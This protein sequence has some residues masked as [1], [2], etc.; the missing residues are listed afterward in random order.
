MGTTTLDEAQRDTLS[1]EEIRERRAEAATQRAGREGY[2]QIA[3]LRVMVESTRK[4]SDIRQ[5]TVITPVQMQEM[6]EIRLSTP[7]QMRRTPSSQGSDSQDQISPAVMNTDPDSPETTDSASQKPSV[8]PQQP[9]PSQKP[10]IPNRRSNVLH[11]AFERGD[12]E[13]TIQRLKQH[14]REAESENHHLRNERGYIHHVYAA[15]KEETAAIRRDFQDHIEKTRFSRQKMEEK[16]ELIQK[17]N[18]NLREYITSMSKAQEP[19]RGEDFYVQ[20]FEEL[21]GHIQSWMAKNSKLNAKEILAEGVQTEVAAFLDKCGPHGI[22][23]SKK[24]GSQIRDLWTSRRTRV[25]LLRHIV[26]LFLFETVFDRFAFGHDRAASEY[27]K[28]IEGDLFRQGPIYTN[29]SMTDI[30]YRVYKDSDNSTS[31]RSS[32]FT[33]SDPPTRNSQAPRNLQ[34][35]SHPYP[36]PSTP[37][38][39]SSGHRICSL[40][41][42]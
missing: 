13:H 26:A 41:V 31:L 30:R 1:E 23:T 17:D 38:I 8:D 11:R 6:Q 14:L 4:D 34:A 37:Q 12:P 7:Q 35:Q 25:P 21:R 22:I 24:F 39:K 5:P 40:K 10:P 32:S 3:K 9:A 20:S 16:C 2:F 33:I 28:W 36:H 19:I 18:E 27:L 15:A 42:A 29:F